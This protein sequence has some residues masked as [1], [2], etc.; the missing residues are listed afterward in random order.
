ML[1]YVNPSVIPHI[2]VLFI[3]FTVNLHVMA[4]HYPSAGEKTSV[5]GIGFF[6]SICHII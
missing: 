4:N 6:L 5:E 3:K 2:L 1:I